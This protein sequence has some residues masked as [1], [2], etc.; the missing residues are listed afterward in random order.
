M[1]PDSATAGTPA[2]SFRDVTVVRGGISI[3]SEIS[4]NVPLGGN[5][6]IIGPN[7]AGKTTLL[8]ALLGQAGFTGE[9]LFNGNPV[10]S[11]IGYV[12]QRFAFDRGMPVSVMEFLVMGI[13]RKPL[14]LGIGKRHQ[15]KALE[16]LSAVQAEGLSGLQLGSLSGG[17]M[18][19][20]LLALALEQEP[21]LL[22]LDEPSA[23]VD[24]KG[25]KVF[26]ELLEDL[27]RRWGFTQLMVSHDLAT[28]THHAT[29][30]ICLNRKVVAEGPPSAVLSADVLKS[31]FGIHMGVVDSSH[32]AGGEK[33]GGNTC[34]GEGGED[35]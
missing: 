9:I 12:P 34:S 14:W 6:A 11:R 16:L 23:G 28:V 10:R 31:L 13:Q 24:I 22:V 33:G 29:H 2:V 17:E 5:T 1:K 20:V 7:G 18:Q 27:S 21:E 8:L 15:E 19:R 25:G 3:L 30:V 4:A 26:C 32:I 35:A